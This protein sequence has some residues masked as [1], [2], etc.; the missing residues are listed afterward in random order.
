MFW[1]ALA[2]PTKDRAVALIDRLV[3]CAASIGE[4]AKISILTGS[5]DV[6][7]VKNATKSMRS[8]IRMRQY[9]FSGPDVLH[10]EGAVL[11]FSPARQRE[12][13]GLSPTEAE[14]AFQEGMAKLSAVL[15]LAES[16]GAVDS[17]PFPPGPT[18]PSSRYRAGTAFIMM[19]MDP[20]Q[21]ELT[22]VAD[23]VK[24]VF[25]TF[26]VNAIRADDIEHE[27]VITDRIREEIRTS[28][29]LFADLTGARPNV[30]YEV[31]FAHALGKRV[32]LFRKAGTG[33]HFDLAG[34][35][36]PD[37]LNLHDLRDKL[38]KRLVFLTNTNPSGNKDT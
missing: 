19:W 38:S 7:D 16:G 25:G 12:R 17:R 24:T 23:T 34:Y 21:P 4:I 26:G 2:A 8:A 5:E 14:G 9:E 27:G 6:Q 3:S 32:I 35:N 22:D 20:G 13:W 15:Q 36:C 18:V 11:G 31:G 33:L 30:Y 1:E 29:F 28:E 37:Y 10:D